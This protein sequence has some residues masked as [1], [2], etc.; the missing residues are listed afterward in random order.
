MTKKNFST[1]PMFSNGNSVPPRKRRLARK[2]RLNKPPTL[3]V[4]STKPEQRFATFTDDSDS[5]DGY[6][7]PLVHFR[8]TMDQ[9]DGDDDPA[10]SIPAVDGADE[11]DITE[12]A[13]HPA[14]NIPA[15]LADFEQRVFNVTAETIA[16]SRYPYPF[17]DALTLLADPFFTAL[18][19]DPEYSVIRF[20]NDTIVS[21]LTFDLDRARQVYLSPV[22]PAPRPRPRPPTPRYASASPPQ[23][24]CSSPALPHDD[25]TYALS[26]AS[27]H[28]SSSSAPTP[29]MLT[30]SSSYSAPTP[31]MPTHP[32]TPLPHL[33][34]AAAPW[35]PVAP[36]YVAPP[37][38][39]QG[40]QMPQW[41]HDADGPK[42]EPEPQP[43]G[44]RRPPSRSSSDSFPDEDYD[45]ALYYYVQTRSS[46]Q[47]GT[48]AVNATASVRDPRD[49]HHP[50]ATRP[51]LVGLDSYSDVTV[52]SCEIVY[53]MHPILEHLSTDGGNT[54]YTEGG[55]VDIVDGPCSFHT[56]PALVAT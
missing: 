11:V 35:D 41:G 14:P 8:M 12:T 19:R 16:R 25:I 32:R 9:S 2:T 37:P 51:I 42:P 44:S 50:L 40:W 30:R 34:L 6:I 31:S 46:F 10:D 45:P 22:V 39:A 15:I 53:N 48:T 38:V 26:H 49:P 56:I 33:G 23:E 55:L 21:C 1:G 52:A 4:S 28:S 13:V 5:D 29:I 54:E 20:P 17:A 18:L 43:W 27:L 3:H 24:S 7:T 47:G 36:P